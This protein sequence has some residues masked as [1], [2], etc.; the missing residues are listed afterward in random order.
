MSMT[1]Q[2]KSHHTIESYDATAI[3]VAVL[4]FDGPTS[5]E[6]SEANPKACMEADET[7]TR[8]APTRRNRVAEQ[9]AACLGFSASFPEALSDQGG[10]L[11]FWSEFGWLE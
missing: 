4:L 6:L 7:P 8:Y 11:N 2:T 1:T 10:L 9:R 3:T 5:M